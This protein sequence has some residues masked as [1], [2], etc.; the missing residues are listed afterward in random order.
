MK[1]WVY[2]DGEEEEKLTLLWICS[3]IDSKKKWEDGDFA[4]P[5]RPPFLH[6][7]KIRREW[8]KWEWDMKC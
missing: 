4:S 8:K 1:Q 6:L 5:I 2:G 3:W 7:S